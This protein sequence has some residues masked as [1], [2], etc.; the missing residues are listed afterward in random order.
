MFGGEAN[1]KCP[2]GT[3]GLWS[4]NWFNQAIRVPSLVGDT[5][6]LLKN[7][8]SPNQIASCVKIQSR[9]F[10]Q[11]KS[12]KGA[13]LLDI[14]SIGISLSLFRNDSALLKNALTKFYDGVFINSGTLQDGIQSDGSFMQHGGLLYNGNYGKD[15]INS[16]IA[17][18][19]ET[20]GTSLIPPRK[21]QIAFEILLS[22]SEWMI[23]ADSK[24][25]KLLW[26]YSAVGRMISF[27]YSDEMSTGGVAID[28]EKVKESAE[29]WDTEAA[30]DAITNR[31]SSSHNK[32]A[33]QGNLVGTRYFY[34]ADYMVRGNTACLIMLADVIT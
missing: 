29:G 5:C 7:Y 16:L 3:P 19:I 6:L 23:M 10:Q 30:L 32:N 18:F 15:F 20:K 25:N 4:E 33:N 12:M 2:C 8:L 27:K 14:S 24:L 28:L 9:A 11:V 13:N 34:N 1:K 22:G 31:L 26:Q 21:V 17:V